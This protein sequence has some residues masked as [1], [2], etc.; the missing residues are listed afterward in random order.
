[1]TNKYTLSPEDLDVTSFE[2][3]GALTSISPIRITIGN[4]TPNTGCFW[5]PPDITIAE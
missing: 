1:M 5:C 2:P 4:P 3:E